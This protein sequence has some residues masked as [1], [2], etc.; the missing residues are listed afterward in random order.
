MTGEGAGDP[1]SVA[2]AVATVLLLLGFALSIVRLW[3]GPRAADRVVALDLVAYHVIG[4]SAL[5]ALRARNV[6]LLAPA[7]VL[8][9]LAF[10]ATVAFARI[11]ERRAGR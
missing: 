5:V 11:L 8:A 3:R 7:L 1:I 9:L 2:V 6:E 4:V 10:L